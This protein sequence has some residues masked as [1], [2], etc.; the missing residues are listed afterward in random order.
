[1]KNGLMIELLAIREE[2]PCSWVRLEAL[3]NSLV[4]FQECFEGSVALSEM[5]GDKIFLAMSNMYFFSQSK[6]IKM[7]FSDAF[8]SVLVPDFVVVFYARAATTHMRRSLV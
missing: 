5:V 4:E 8:Y 7:N 3:S 6:G 1:M 2:A